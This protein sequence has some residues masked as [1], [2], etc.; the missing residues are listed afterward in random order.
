MYIRIEELIK[1][2]LNQMKKESELSPEEI[3]SMKKKMENKI[4]KSEKN[5]KS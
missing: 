4:T 5:K 1:R 3:K 2:L